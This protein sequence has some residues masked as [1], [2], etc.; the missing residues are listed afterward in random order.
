MI[1]GRDSTGVVGYN[2]H[3]KHFD[4][5]K[6]ATDPNTLMQFKRYDGVVSM[7]KNV[8]IGHNR[9]ATR[10]KINRANAHPF[11]AEGVCGV[12][13]G[14]LPYEAVRMLKDH[15]K[16]DTDSEALFNN[17]DM[18]GVDEVIPKI[19]GAWSLVWIDKELN[20]LNFLRNKERPMHYCFSKDG[21]KMYWASEP[22]MLRGVL[23]REN[24]ELYENT[25]YQTS[26]N[27]HIAWDIPTGRNAWTEPKVKEVLGGE[28]KATFHGGTY[29]RGIYQGGA[30]GGY[31]EDWS[32][33][34]KE[35]ES[36]T[37]AKSADAKG[38]KGATETAAPEKKAVAATVEKK[39]LPAPETRSNVVALPGARKSGRFRMFTDATA[40]DHYRSV[41]GKVI[42]KED[43]DRLSDHACAFCS[44]TVEWGQPIAFTRQVENFLCE[45]CMYDPNTREVS[46]ITTSC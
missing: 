17:I 28:P 29:N 27:S 5:I 39:A 41:D 14:T 30:Y 12:H 31:G 46:G 21:V 22:W 15:D 43:F 11:D 24:V 36:R 18:D 35:I 42:K 8:I 37:A 10:G 3:T 34:D 1:R 40:P 9:S 4:I 13:N 45:D 25:I 7:Q 23:T 6:E 38:E 20:T 26:E 16:Y 19:W 33:W 2:K 44:N 32:Q